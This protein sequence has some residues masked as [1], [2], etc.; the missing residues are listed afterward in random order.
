MWSDSASAACCPQRYDLASAWHELLLS[1]ASMPNRRSADRDL[2]RVAGP[3]NRCTTG[4]SVAPAGA[5]PSGSRRR[6]Q[7]PQHA[8]PHW[9][10]AW[11]PALPGW[12]RT[13]LLPPQRG[14]ATCKAVTCKAAVAS[15]THSAA[16]QTPASLATDC[17]TA[18][19]P[20]ASMASGGDGRKQSLRPGRREPVSTGRS[21]QACGC[22]SA[23]RPALGVVRD[24]GEFSTGSA[25][26]PAS[27]APTVLPGRTA[28]ILHD[29]AVGVL[30]RRSSS[31]AIR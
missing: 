9:H 23:S 3:T 1:G 28:A 4:K 8:M 30:S 7:P 19:P 24:D 26:S 22:G 25:P 5:P 15:A 2:N 16:R 21:R 6:N 11:P 20:E 12:T 18:A 10:S 27:S 14:A 31:L 13:N 17:L 29:E